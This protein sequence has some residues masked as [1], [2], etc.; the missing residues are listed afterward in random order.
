MDESSSHLFFVCPLYSTVWQKTLSWINISSALHSSA[1]D[2]LEQFTGLLGRGRVRDNKFSVI[3]F[4]CI[5]VVWKIRIRKIFRSSNGSLDDWIEE[6]QQPRV[7]VQVEYVCRWKYGCARCLLR[8][9]QLHQC[10]VY[11][12]GIVLSQCVDV[13]SVLSN[14]S[15]DIWQQFSCGSIYSGLK[16]SAGRKD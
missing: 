13:G 11:R 8:A 4:A 10:G 3:W 15:G 9:F 7:Y 2:H 5:W 16:L 14:N 1:I 6:I 12:S